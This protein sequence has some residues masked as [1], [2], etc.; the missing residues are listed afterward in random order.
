MEEAKTRNLYADLGLTDNWASVGEIDL[1]H[2]E[3]M[4]KLDP[5]V[6]PAAAPADA[7]ELS[8]ARPAL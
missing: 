3:L 8:K 5:E 6:N 4:S 7:A 2:M 1:A